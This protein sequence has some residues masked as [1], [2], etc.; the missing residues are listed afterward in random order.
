MIF[1]QAW[2][3]PSSGRRQAPLGAL[4]R[5]LNL[6]PVHARKPGEEVVPCQ[7]AQG[8]LTFGHDDNRRSHL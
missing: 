5:G 3:C 6:L 2:P 8:K 7:A 4:Q 1:K